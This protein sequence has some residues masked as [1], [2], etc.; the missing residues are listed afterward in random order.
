MRRGLRSKPPDQAPREALARAGCGDDN[1][2]DMS[3]SLLLVLSGLLATV[4]AQSPQV[5][6][7]RIDGSV[8]I[9][10]M[11]RVTE[12]A[13]EL[14]VA[15]EAVTIARADVL[16]LHGGVPRLGATVT[17]RLVGGD[18]VR[19]EL[20]GGDSGGESLMIESRSL[21]NVTLATDR[22]LALVVHKV[23]GDAEA[24]E[25]VLPTEGEYDEAIFLP[26]KRGF[27]TLFG[28][29]HRFT[30]D[31]VLFA[32][33][34]SATPRSY[35][36][37]QIAAVALRG[38]KAA[39][40]KATALLITRGGDAIA[41]DVVRAD[42]AALELA[43][44]RGRPFT[45]AWSEVATLLF[46]GND[47]VFLSELQPDAVEQGSALAGEDEALY[48][49][50]RDRNVRGGFL[51]VGDRTYARGLGVHSRCVLTFTVPAGYD[52]F[53][54]AVGIDDE[55]RALPAR[56]DADVAVLVDGQVVAELARVRVGAEA[57]SLGRLSVSGGS[58]LSLRVE[59]GAGLD[60]G[61]RVD[62][63]HAVLV[64]KRT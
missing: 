29:I 27:D 1:P 39:A 44:D 50:R 14:R 43:D 23:A 21:G 40:G 15:S 13:V 35:T 55:V 34:S 25:F 58:K 4:P 42:G 59:F 61:D 3:I 31:G 24:S 2:I 51:V 6:V 26:A 49:W 62:W 41:V 46:R 5:V 30:N 9:G 11:A 37:D 60:L 19:G 63:L 16:A 57:Q 36:L 48:P 64:R 52:T 33:T 38:S 17:A 8:V 12:A 54:V 56:G 45:L 47:R 32:A 53:C 22:L 28:A 7:S 10:E 18:E 20:R